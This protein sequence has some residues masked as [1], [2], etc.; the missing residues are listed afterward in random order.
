MDHYIFFDPSAK[1]PNYYQYDSPLQTSDGLRIELGD[2]R[3]RGGN[4]SV[5]QCV[6][7]SSGEELAVKFLLVLSPQR[8]QRFQRE[9][10][11]LRQLKSDHT[12]R[13]RGEGVVRA[14]RSG[15]ESLV[16]IPF[17]VMDLADNNLFNL[18]KSRKNGLPYEE[19]SGQFRGLCSALAE[20]HGIAIHRDI[21]PENILVL[22]GRWLLSDYGLCTAV[23][24]LGPDLTGEMEIMGPKFWLCPEAHNRRIGCGDEIT[25]ASDVYQLAAIFWYAVTGRHPSGNL[26][27]SDWTGPEKL[28]TLVA[29]SLRHDSSKRPQDGDML[30]RALEE[31]LLS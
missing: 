3:G 11:L 22:G 12:I 23:D 1:E 21:K 2:W 16:E 19:Y 20:L 28:F 5:Y 15:K 9:V 27:A 17:L 31:S 8:R 10:A 30:L 18:V 13:Y 6:D 25:R 7:V 14:K 24:D 26:A 4:G 29:D